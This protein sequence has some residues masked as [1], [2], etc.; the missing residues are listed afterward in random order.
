MA[1]A[2]PSAATALA[3]WTPGRRFRTGDRGDVDKEGKG[4]GGASDAMESA[5]AQR[6]AW[7]WKMRNSKGKTGGCCSGDQY[8]RGHLH[9]VHANAHHPTGK[10]QRRGRGGM[11]CRSPIA[12]RAGQCRRT[13]GM[14]DPAGGW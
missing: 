13:A 5:S 1:G 11:W 10:K 6:K 14:D 8:A 3:E 2:A 9:I 4:G 12:R 7:Q